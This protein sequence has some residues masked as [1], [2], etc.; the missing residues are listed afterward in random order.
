MFG[1]YYSLL[2]DKKRLKHLVQGPGARRTFRLSSRTPQI[3][4]NVWS[5]Q[6]RIT[7]RI[8][9]K[10]IWKKLFNY[11][12]YIFNS[13]C[14]FCRQWGKVDTESSKVFFLI[15]A[16]HMYLKFMFLFLIKFFFYF[17]YFKGIFMKESNTST[18]TC[19]IFQI[20]YVIVVFR[21]Q[22]C[23]SK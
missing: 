7:K 9:R 14:T 15:T 22:P 10:I 16:L 3:P 23:F 19:P 2:K 5:E 12:N 21:S 8:K 1:R 17:K 20:D 11:L 4:F 18:P 13:Q 6:I